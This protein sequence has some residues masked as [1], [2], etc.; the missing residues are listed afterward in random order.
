[1]MWNVQYLYVQKNIYIWHVDSGCSKH[2]KGDP[3]KFIS[4]KIKKGKVTF[5]NNLSSKIIGK[6]IVAIR[7]K[8]KAEF[9]FLVKKLKPNILSV[10]QTCDQGHIC[11]FDSK[12]CEIKRKDSGKLVGIAVRT[13][14]NVYILENEEQCK[15]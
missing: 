2:V 3:N 9:F 8:I 11:I 13:P 14:R 7:D 6:G 4:L 1:M 12:K 10:S 5:R 15:N